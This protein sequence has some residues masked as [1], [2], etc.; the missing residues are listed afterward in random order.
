MSVKFSFMVE[1]SL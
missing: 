1:L